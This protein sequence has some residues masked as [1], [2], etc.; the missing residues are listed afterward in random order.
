MLDGRGAVWWPERSTLIVADLHL[1]KAE[2]FAAQGRFL[3]P[4]DSRATLARLVELINAHRPDHVVS[5]GDGFHRR[6]G[7]DRLD[8]ADRQQLDALGLVT[9]WTWL[10]G[11]HDPDA[12]NGHGASAPELQLGRLHLRHLPTPHPGQAEIAGHLHPKAAL[13]VRGRRLARPCFV[14]D[15]QRLLLPALG[16]FTGGLD[17]WAPA[18]AGLFAGPFDVLL[19]GRDGRLRQLPGS[20]LEGARRVKVRQGGT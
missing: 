19:C 6:D 2:A 17:V 11:N 9:R 3:P 15:G 18:I 5:L 7:Y 10:S 13:R 1:A 20:R 14:T 12:P 4:Y 8:A 16:T